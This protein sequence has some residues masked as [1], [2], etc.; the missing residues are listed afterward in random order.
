MSR[1][2]IEILCV[3][4]NEVFESLTSAAKAFKVT[5]MAI[6]NAIV[7]RGKCKGNHFLYNATPTANARNINLLLNNTNEV[8]IEL[9]ESIKNY[10]R[11]IEILKDNIFV[12][13]FRS[14]YNK[15][16]TIDECAEI[17]G[18]SK[19]YLY[20]IFRTMKIERGLD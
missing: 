9:T 6:R 7:K 10:Q 5:P 18:Y 3:E 16:V 14:W 12:E 17:S 19:A 4:T 2:N 8:K 20:Q 1:A 15:E 13:L 11:E